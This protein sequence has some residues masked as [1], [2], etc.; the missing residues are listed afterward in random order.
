M[1]VAL[2]S[3]GTCV[4][5][6]P[7]LDTE[8]LNFERFNRDAVYTWIPQGRLNA[9]VAMQYTGPGQEVVTIEGRVFPH[10]F[11]GL[12]TLANLRN[13]AAAGK[14]MPL[15]RYYPATDDDGKIVQGIA[16]QVLGDWVIVR[17][18]AGERDIAGDGVANHVDF[19]IELAR[20]GNDDSTV[21]QN[22]QVTTTTESTQAA[23]S[24]PAAQG[25][26]GPGA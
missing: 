19:Q 14:P 4:F 3:L 18:R 17:I 8:T 25:S 20:Y 23:N 12:A 10:W 7:A 1:A 15:I 5:N 24:Q 26:Y 6:V 9:P 11:G 2:M 13:A 16:A 21:S 22:T